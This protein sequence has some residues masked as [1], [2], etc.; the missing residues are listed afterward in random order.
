MSDL[1][2][3]RKSVNVIYPKQRVDR[4]DH[5]GKTEG[6]EKGGQFMGGRRGGERSVLAWCLQN[7]RKQESNGSRREREVSS[8]GPSPREENVR[9]REERAGQEVV[10]EKRKEKVRGKRGEKEEGVTTGVTKREVEMR[11]D[12]S[13]F[14]GAAVCWNIRSRRLSARASWKHITAFHG[15]RNTLCGCTNRQTSTRSRSFNPPLSNWCVSGICW[16]SFDVQME[17]QRMK[18]VWEKLTLKYVIPSRPS[19]SLCYSCCL[20]VFAS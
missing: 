16:W 2:D 17:L 14:D 15:S 3:H 5:W 6:K 9:Q 19:L 7:L 1:N 8:F 13:Y 12:K 11:G 10:D 18:A 4:E 20:C